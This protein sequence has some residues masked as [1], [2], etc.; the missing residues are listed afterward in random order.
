MEQEKTLLKK[1]KAEIL[2]TLKEQAAVAI[3]PMESIVPETLGNLIKELKDKSDENK[4]RLEYIEQI[5]R[6]K[7]LLEN[8]L[9]NEMRNSVNGNMP[10]ADLVA[11]VS[12]FLRDICEN[13]FNKI[14]FDS[15]TIYSLKV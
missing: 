13:L 11:R 12:E 3:P 4:R 6:E 10:F 2:N 15:A 7:K 9:R 14:L 8:Q 5:E 1:Q